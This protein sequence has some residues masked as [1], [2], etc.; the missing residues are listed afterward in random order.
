MISRRISFDGI[1]VFDKKWKG[2][3]I[4]SKSNEQLANELHQ[5]INR[6]LERR[7]FYSSL[8]DN[9]SGVALADMELI[10]KY[11]KGIRYLLCAIDLFS[12]YAWVVP[13]KD[14]KGVTTVNAF[15]KFLNSSKRKLN[16]IWADQGSKFYNNAFKK[17][18]KENHIEMYST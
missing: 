5:P 12:K 9:I 18:L 16:K 14:H 7:K 1:Q 17:F 8:K 2:S 13:I 4:K 15:Q 3:G 11:K 6:K 10:S